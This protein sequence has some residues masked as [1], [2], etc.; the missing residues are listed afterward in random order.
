VGEIVRAAVAWRLDRAAVLALAI[1]TVAAGVTFGS[2]AAGGS[3]SYG[4]IS[5]A[6]LW[7]SGRLWV[8]QPWVQEVPWGNPTWSFTPLGY[9][10]GPGRWLVEPPI[11]VPPR[12]RWAIVPTYS[13]GLPLLMAAAKRLAG[14][15]AV[16][17]VV[18][19]L[20][21]ALVLATYG[22]GVRVGSP[23]AG[24]L[25][26]WLAAT[27]PSFLCMLMAPMSDVPAASAW[28]VAFW[29]LLG[30]SVASGLGAGLAAGLAVLIRPNLAPLSAVMVLW[31]A[32]RA[33]R[34]P[35]TDR[36]RHIW[37]G[38]GMLA[39]V[40]VGVMATATTN[41][42]L[43]GSPF[44]SGYLPLRTLFDRANFMPNLRH[45][46]TWFADVHTP[47]AFVGLAALAVPAAWLWPRARDRSVVLVFGAFVAGLWALYCFYDV[48][49]SAFYLRFL[50]PGWPFICLGMASA[51]LALTRIGRGP[52]AAT[53][54]VAVVI[55]L[56]IRGV[57]VA[58][59]SGWFAQRDDESRYVT[60]GEMVRLSTSENSVVIAL[61]HSGSVRYYAG[62]MTM[63]YESLPAEWLD[64]SVAWLADRGVHTYAVLDD[65]E[66]GRVKAKFAGQASL[67][68]LE[69]PVFTFRQTSLYDLIP[70]AGP[71]RPTQIIPSTASDLRAVPPAPLPRLIFKK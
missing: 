24:L 5:E 59:A 8:S 52:V 63:Q 43:Y 37:R 40:G 6:D 64:R 18:P 38:V 11:A 60:V 21:G 58:E 15:R 28:A 61:Q 44:S 69:T 67:A 49:D 54:V 3:D 39:G 30:S 68:R 41:W 55:G 12:D 36:R 31:L 1:A 65:W 32:L 2:K 13:P 71:A 53:V 17:W 7:L 9:K 48:F 26:S 57:R 34:A 20:G 56:G 42:A 66:V 62:R 51:A 27:S 19:L 29:S 10:P 50:L 22:L 45:Y 16:F 47:I 46:T 70:P 14:H 35:R 25:A 33:W 23:G 4:Y